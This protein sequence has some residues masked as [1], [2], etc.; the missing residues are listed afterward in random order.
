MRRALRRPFGIFDLGTLES[1]YPDGAPQTYLEM[2]YRVVGK[3]TAMMAALH[4][5]DHLDVIGPLGQGFDQGAA[6]EEKVLVG[7]GVGLAPLYFLAKELV[8]R[9]P[10]RLFVGG[11]LAG[12]RQAVP[13]IHLDDEVGAGRFLVEQEEAAGPFNLIAPEQT[14]NAQFMRAVARRLH[15]P[16]WF[17][18]PGFLLRL[19]LGGMSVLVTEGRY[20]RPERLLALGYRFRYARVEDALSETFAA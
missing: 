15:R 13:W 8:K 9:S 10:V 4:H 6:G 16:Y 2:L 1:E 12:G 19:I 7:G 17:P 3:G 5:G 14:S 18:T 20:S 11:P